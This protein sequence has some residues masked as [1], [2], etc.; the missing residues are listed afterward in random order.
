M[1]VMGSVPFPW[2]RCLRGF[3]VGELEIVVPV[4]PVAREL[5]AAGD[6]VAAVAEG[7]GESLREAGRVAPEPPRP[8]AHGDPAIQRASTTIAGWTQLSPS[9]AELRPRRVRQHGELVWRRRRPVHRGRYTPIAALQG[10]PQV[11]GG[12]PFSGRPRSRAGSTESCS[13][14]ARISAADADPR[15]GAGPVAAPDPHGRTLMIVFPLRRAV[16]LKAA[17]ASSRVATVPMFVRS[18]PSRTRCTTSPS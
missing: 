11:A 17:T 4:H 5:T 1:R 3:P 9:R 2:A 7:A 13:A 16:E 12:V 15:G 8:G 6:R 18:R 14:V 10:R